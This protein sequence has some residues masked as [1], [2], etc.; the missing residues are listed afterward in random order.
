V[1]QHCCR[2]HVTLHD[3]DTLE[4]LQDRLEDLPAPIVVG[5]L[6]CVPDVGM[7][8]CRCSGM[9]AMAQHTCPL[10]MC[11][12]CVRWAG[13]LEWRRP[14]GGD[15]CHTRLQTGGA[16]HACVCVCVCVCVAAPAATAAAR[17][18]AS[19]CTPVPR[20][21]RCAR[22]A[23]ALSPQLVRPEPPGR[24]G[25]GF[26]PVQVVRSFSL[27]P[28]KVLLGR[29]RRPVSA[30]PVP[31]GVRAAAVRWH[32]STRAADDM[33]ARAVRAPAGHGLHTHC[34]CPPPPTQTH[35]H[36]PNPPGG[37]GGGLHRPGAC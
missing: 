3:S 29:D 28:H 23:P 25:E 20:R 7:C 6:V 15:H 36:T 27:I 5:S 1:P 12:T 16:R 19:D 37:H 26:A 31:A 30:V 22:V 32:A 24:A 13:G 34:L 14:P 17:V 21:P 11:R 10:G 18:Q 8:Q 9:P 33:C 35:E 2:Y 4:V